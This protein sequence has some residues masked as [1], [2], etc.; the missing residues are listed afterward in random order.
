MK[1]KIRDSSIGNT[2]DNGHRDDV[3]SYANVVKNQSQGNGE[4]DSKPVL[5]LDDSCVNTQDY[6][7]CLNGKVKEV[8]VLENLKVVLGNEGF[9]DID[10][11]YMG[12]VCSWFSQ[13]IQASSEFTTDERVTMVEIEGKTHWVRAIEIPG[14]TP[15]LDDQNDEESDLEDAECE[16][17]FKKDFG[18]SDE[19]VQ[20]E[21]DVS[22]VFD[23]DV[24]EE[25]PKSK[26]NVVSNKMKNN[27]EASTKESLEFPPGFTPRENDV[28]NLGFYH[29]YNKAG[30]ES[31]KWIHCRERLEVL[32]LGGSYLMLMDEF[33]Y[34]WDNLHR[35]GWTS[36]LVFYKCLEFNR[37]KD[38]VGGGE[39]FLSIQSH[40]KGCNSLYRVIKAI[41]G[42]DGK[43]GSG[44]KVGYKSIWRFEMVF[45]RVTRARELRSVDGFDEYV[46]GVVRGVTPDRC[47]IGS[48]DGS[49][50]EL[51]VV[52]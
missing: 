43:N 38:V 40:S 32:E 25:N 37:K 34:R 24:E 49:G 19:E 39:I 1:G 15:D 17:V 9:T 6:S 50:D 18:K 31:L 28:E 41:H 8:E 5:V 44:L 20:G 29:V 16:E 33:S 36:H 35:A 4:N 14:W 3:S 23:T 47:G 11:R 27:K 22:R 13:L 21:N 46:E 45:C 7:C 48:F 42:E 30:G 2:K 12:E 51:L 52:W 26:D 10:L